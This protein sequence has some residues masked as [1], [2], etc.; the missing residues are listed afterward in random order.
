[1]LPLL[2]R[3]RLMIEHAKQW[4]EKFRQQFIDKLLDIYF[5]GLLPVKFCMLPAYLLGGTGMMMLIG[6]VPAHDTMLMLGSA[7]ALFWAICLYTV[8]I[9][10]SL[11]LF[12]SFQSPIARLAIPVLAIWVWSTMFVS[13]LLAPMS[14]LADPAGMYL[15]YLAP[16]L[17]E[18]FI[19]SRVFYDD[20]YDKYLAQYYPIQED[21]DE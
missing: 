11:G 20:H 16:V 1:M 18:A 8:F 17:V 4:C 14:D 6:K 21:K 5:D 19:L 9:F 3:H 2:Y 13:S 7:P 12:T 15:L 10:R